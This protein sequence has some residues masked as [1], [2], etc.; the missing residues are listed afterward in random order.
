MICRM[1]VISRERSRLLWFSLSRIVGK[2]IF[3]LTVMSVIGERAGFLILD[4]MILKTP[5][6]S[7]RNNLTA[8][9]GGDDLVLAVAAQNNNTIVVV[10]S[11]GPLIVEP[12]INHPNV[13][14]VSFSF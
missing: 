9:A 5:L 1:R 7:C 11:V 4:E 10:H 14:A 2:S 12:W 8:W 3:R 6:H 13:T